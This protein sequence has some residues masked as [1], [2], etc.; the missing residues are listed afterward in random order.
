VYCITVT[1]QW[2]NACVV[3]VVGTIAWVLDALSIIDIF[4]RHLLLEDLSSS[5]AYY[6]AILL[7]INHPNTQPENFL[8]LTHL[9]L[10]Y[11]PNV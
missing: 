3:V 6:D 1:A 11:L 7:L 4:L 10:Q 9:F 2:S 5:A 8:C